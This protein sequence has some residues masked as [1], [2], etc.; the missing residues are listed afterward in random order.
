MFPPQAVV[1]DLADG[2][3]FFKKYEPPPLTPQRG[4][5]YY[6]YGPMSEPNFYQILGVGRSASTNQIR[7][8]YRELVKRHHPDL[9]STP[10]E[11]AQATDKLR[12]I[13][14]AYA[15][16]GN[17]K[18][19]HDYDQ[20][21][22]QKPRPRVRVRPS[23]R[24]P[25]AARPQPKPA[26]RRG[27]RKIAIAWRSFSR[28]RAGYALVAVTAV[29]LLIYAARSVPRLT[30]AWTLVEKVEI[31]SASTV[32]SPMSMPPANAQERGKNWSAVA[33]FTSVS[34]C[35]DALKKSVREDERAGG[36]AVFDERNGMMAITVQVKKDPARPES[37]ANPN[38][39]SER[40]AAGDVAP[41]EGS[42][43]ARAAASESP[44]SRVRNLECR[45]TQRMETEPWFQQTLR[46]WGLL[47]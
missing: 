23:R 31:S 14:E 35:T 10:A 13:N 18:R 16:L 7:S 29:I 45:A 17:S 41:G 39:E 2:H 28:K 34:E 19:R 1:L 33:Q 40:A 32:S 27:P 21:L 11:K 38:A 4:F 36:K 25:G 30:T 24:G 42:S 3:R 44:V 15:V 46:G 9:F 6:P 37:S 8:A 12:Q 47:R 26:A 5:K 22:V 20:S 43:Q